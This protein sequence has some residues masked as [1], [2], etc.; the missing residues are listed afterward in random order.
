MLGRMFP[1]ASP[2]RVRLATVLGLALVHAVVLTWFARMGLSPDRSPPPPHPPLLLLLNRVQPSK[3]TTPAPEAPPQ[4]TVARADRAA[5]LPSTSITVAPEAT[6][7]AQEALPPTATA[8]P[9]T[10][11]P[12]NT[13]PPLDLRLPRAASAAW[14]HRPAP[15]DDPRANTAKATFESTL[16]TAMGGDGRWA[17]ERIDGDRVRFR[18]GN[19]CVDFIRSRAEQLDAFHQSVSPKPW[20]TAG[21]KDC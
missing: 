12:A 16:Q 20:S 10:A 7:R 4:R 2:Q 19:T 11:P 5:P 15:M 18:R 9:T 1:M 8:E 21:P 14:R 3:P 17:E 6:P 13:P